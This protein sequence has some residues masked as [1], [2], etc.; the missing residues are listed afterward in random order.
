MSIVAFS[1][2][3]DRVG[4]LS[5]VCDSDTSPVETAL[6]E[7]R[8]FAATVCI[9]ALTVWA[10]ALTTDI[11]PLAGDVLAPSHRWASLPYALTFVGAAVATLPAGLLDDLLSRRAALT[12]AAS[13]AAA[14]GIVAAEGYATGVFSFLALGAL[15]LGMAQGFGF[16]YRHGGLGR[17]A[18]R[19]RAAAIILGSGGV[20]ALLAPA[21]VVAAT[22]IAGPLAPALIL[23][24]AGVIE[25]SALIVAFRAPQ[26]V[27]SGMATVDG[28][29]F[30]PR[31]LFATLAAC[32]VWF[33][34]T[35]LMAQAAPAMQLCGVAGGVIAG[36]V[37]SHILWMCAPAFAL[38]G[39]VRI[40]GGIAAASAGLVFTAGALAVFSFARD[41][42][43]FA[44]VMALAGIGWSLAML[45]ASVTLYEGGAPP[46]W[47]L[48]LH[49]GSLFAAALLGA[50]SASF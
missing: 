28:K 12:L 20:A 45:A 6:P 1:R 35:R 13:L 26:A 17:E 18:N 25:A 7:E 47:L 11:L 10:M 23:A 38:G 3:G 40:I 32:A 37:A 9:F 27:L 34:M 44:A 43:P 41:V 48:G 5:C 33:G 8:G 21:T 42:L 22:S 39:F 14:G 31:R 36:L 24:C 16:F 30:T 29:G 46:R 49:D 2:G 50:V 4:R 15:W 19:S